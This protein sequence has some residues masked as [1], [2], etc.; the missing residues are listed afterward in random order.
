MKINILDTSTLITDPHSF[1][2]FHNSEV[3]LPIAVLN[4]LDK[5]KKQP[6]DVGRNARVC[7]KEIDYISNIGDISTGIVIDNNILFKIDSTY[8][9]VINDSR[10]NGF[11]DPSYG[12]TQ[13]LALAYVYYLDFPSDDI[14]LV[15]NDINLRIKAKARGLNAESYETDNT[16]VSELY[17][18]FQEIKDEKTG[19]TLQQNGF[20]DP[21][22]FGFQDVNHN[23]FI[24][25]QADNCDGIAMGRKVSDEK[26]KLVK[27]YYPW[28]ISPKNK[29]QAFAIDLIMDPTIDLISLIGSAGTGKSLCVLASALE[30]VFQ[31]KAYDKLVIYR[32][33][34]PV[35]SDIGYMPG[36]KEEKL[37]PWFQAIMDNLE[38]LLGSKNN[39]WKR[40]LELWQKKGKIEM[41]ALTYIRGRSIS[42]SIIMLDEAQ[43]L[44]KEEMK[45]ILT[46]AGENTKI[47]ITGDISQIDAPHLDASNNGLTYII[48]KFKNSGLSGHITLTQGERSRLASKAA[49]IL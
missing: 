43:N 49:E 41:E 1:K 30:L 16:A 17:T 45:T 28:G 20:I 12:D 21:N 33:I 4:E 10:F 38:F 27:K 13:I 40:D 8:Y 32:P 36:S 22:V 37:A 9:D 19:L 2:N 15:S 7:I 6:D 11:G 42:N 29:E 34:Q 46:R 3:C 18:G 14:T 39:E 31:K 26:I 35:G 5:L 24:M 48:E 23:E 44:N 25:F 47:I